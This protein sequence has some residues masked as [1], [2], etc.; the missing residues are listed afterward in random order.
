MIGFIGLGIMGSRMAR[1]L[2]KNGQ[3]LVVYNR[4]KEKA[5]E[6]LE[7]GA[8]WAGS[9]AEVS[10]QADIVFTMLAEPEAVKQAALGEQG[11]LKEMGNHGIWIDCSTVNPSFSREMAAEAGQRGVRFLDAPVAGTKIPAEK[12]ELM[13]FVGGNQDDLEQV[14]PLL[15]MMGKV[16]RHVGENGAGTSL[17]MVVN[18][19]LGQAMAAFSE[20]VALGERMGLSRDVLFS[21]LIGGPVAAPFLA[22]K[23][24][25]IDQGRFDT[26]F[27]LQWMNKDLH[28]VTETAYELGLSLPLAGMTEDLY[29]M[30]KQQ[31]LGR[32]DFSAIYRLYQKD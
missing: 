1:N 11:F 32:E 31:G 4:T 8:V 28:L 29:G 25:K 23:K 18:L 6:L 16:I 10:R 20:A 30:A 15:E 3:S 14:M 5:G 21:T 12:G 27:P 7:H 17:K 22:S 2:Q 26:E 13:F 19:M 9:P 24:D